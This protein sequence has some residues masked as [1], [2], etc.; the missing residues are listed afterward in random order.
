MKK[1][2]VILGVLAIACVSVTGALAVV[3][4]GHDGDLDHS[5]HTACPVYQAGL[6]SL[7]C[8]SP[9][10]SFFIA[11]L[12]LCFFKE[13]HTPSFPRIFRSHSLLRAP[14]IFS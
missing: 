10:F 2:F 7:E 4:H 13:K 3:P 6:H 5:R 9:V 1:F 14:P 11:F 12:F 8:V